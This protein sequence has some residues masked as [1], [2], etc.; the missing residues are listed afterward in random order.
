[1]AQQFNAIYE[2]GVLRPLS[3]VTLHERECVSVTVV[4]QSQVAG[5]LVDESFVAH[6]S[7]QA[8]DNVSLD[9]VRNA[10][11]PIVGNMSDAIRHERDAR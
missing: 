10:L 7:S 5:G 1:M 11:A 8:D 6:C 4:K 3:P 2:N 9:D